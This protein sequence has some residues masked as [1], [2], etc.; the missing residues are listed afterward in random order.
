MRHVKLQGYCIIIDEDI[1]KNVGSDS[2]LTVGITN[3][4][5]ILRLLF[6]L[7]VYI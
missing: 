5:T 3:T 6:F 7:Q 2:D 4:I 1:V